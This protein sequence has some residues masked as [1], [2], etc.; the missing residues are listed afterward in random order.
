MISQSWEVMKVENMRKG[1][2]FMA[3]GAFHNVHVVESIPWAVVGHP[4]ISGCISV[5]IYQ[6]IQCGP[7]YF[8]FARLGLLSR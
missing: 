5:N 3:I 7:S 8:L 6:P 1:K 2:G 4:S